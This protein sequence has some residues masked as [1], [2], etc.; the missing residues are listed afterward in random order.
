[1]TGAG[2]IT[3]RTSDLGRYTYGYEV[4]MKMNVS[5]N[6]H[7]TRMEMLKSTKTII[8]PK[9]ARCGRAF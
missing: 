4:L 1:M 6:V 9:M 3:S 5:Y 7:L 2:V 8:I